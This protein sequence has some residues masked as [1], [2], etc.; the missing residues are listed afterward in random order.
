MESGNY[1]LAQ[2][3]T[4]LKNYKKF[5]TNNLVTKGI[6]QYK[7]CVVTKGIIQYKVRVG[8][9]GYFTIR[10]TITHN[11]VSLAAIKMSND[12]QKSQ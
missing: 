12:L 3:K 8:P 2:N 11:Q 4:N 7:V 1:K 6:I 9:E 10:G 5:I